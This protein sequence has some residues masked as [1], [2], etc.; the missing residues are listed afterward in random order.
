MLLLRCSFIL[1]IFTFFLTFWMYFNTQND[2]DNCIASEKVKYAMK[3]HGILSAVCDNNYYYFIRNGK[4][5]PLFTEAEEKL[6][7]RNL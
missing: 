2:P 7:L 4:K 1:S 3:Y 6:R 5:C